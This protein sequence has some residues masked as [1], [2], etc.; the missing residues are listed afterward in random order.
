[1]VYVTHCHSHSFPTRRS[2][3]LHGRDRRTWGTLYRLVCWP[4]GTQS[5]IPDHQFHNGREATFLNSGD[6]LRLVGGVL[7]ITRG[8]SSG[9]GR[10]RCPGEGITYDVT[11]GGKFL[12]LQCGAGCP[13]SLEEYANCT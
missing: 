13:G 2:S 7:R 1:P 11:S 6:G 8:S 4:H 12:I 9:L 3:D 5:G 10:G